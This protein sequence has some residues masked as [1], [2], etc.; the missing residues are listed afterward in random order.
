MA[1]GRC[2]C[3]VWIDPSA[4]DETSMPQSAFGT[5]KKPIELFPYFQVEFRAVSP[6]RCRYQNNPPCPHLL[7]AGFLNP[8]VARA[9]RRSFPPPIRTPGLSTSIRNENKQGMTKT[10]TVSPYLGEVADELNSPGV[11]VAWPLR[12]L[13]GDSGAAGRSQ[14]GRR[15]VTSI[16]GV[17]AF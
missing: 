5:R 11:C 14:S 12:Q 16:P 13:T 1:T 15:R 6:W 2:W 10:R 17:A 7:L 3:A 8:Q 9:L 4:K